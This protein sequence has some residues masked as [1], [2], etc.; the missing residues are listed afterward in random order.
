MKKHNNYTYIKT[1]GQLKQHI[2]DI[3]VCY[4]YTDSAIDGRRFDPDNENR[5]IQYMWMF[6]LTRIEDTEDT[7]LPTND[8]DPITR[9][10]LYGTN[11]IRLYQYD[12]LI[13]ITYDKPMP[14]YP[15]LSLTQETT[16]SAQTYVRLATPQEKKIYLNLNRKKRMYGFNKENIYNYGF[17]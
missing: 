13:G 17:N 3:I 12:P 5:K 14:M 7:I 4:Y 10:T 9:R 16:N 11:S 6:K 15:S 1:I 8:N 2:G